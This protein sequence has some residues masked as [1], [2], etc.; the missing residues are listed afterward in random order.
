M[1]VEKLIEILSGV[2]RGKTVKLMTSG[3]EMEL[4]WMSDPHATF[5]MAREISKKD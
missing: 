2:D 1:T 4:V 3:G 5:F